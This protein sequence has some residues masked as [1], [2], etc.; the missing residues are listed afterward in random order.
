MKL[1]KLLRHVRYRPPNVNFFWFINLFD[2]LSLY[3][4]LRSRYIYFVVRVTQ[5]F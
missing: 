3:I 4:Y 1:V 2:F 5:T